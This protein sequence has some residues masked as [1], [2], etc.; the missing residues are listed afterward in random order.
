MSMEKKNKGMIWILFVIGVV[1]VGGI[2]FCITKPWQNSV[3]PHSQ[4]EA[5]GIAESYI[6]DALPTEELTEIIFWSGDTP[7]SIGKRE[8][9]TKIQECLHSM[10]GKKVEADGEDVPAGFVRIE[11]VYQKQKISLSMQSKRINIDGTLYK[12]E[13]ANPLIDLCRSIAESN[14]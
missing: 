5:E 10:K 4:V 3:A 12:M 7:I 14:G 2:I 13:D 6:K 11:L 9:I 1:L 8:D